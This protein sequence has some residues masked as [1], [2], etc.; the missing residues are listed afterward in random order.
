[1][2]DLRNSRILVVDDTDFNRLVLATIL[3]KDYTITTS[4]DGPGA[5]AHAQNDPPPDLILLDIMMPGMDGFEVCRRL[6][7][8]KTTR[9]IPII[10]I[11]ALKGAEHTSKGFSLGAVDYITKPFD[12]T[13]ILARVKTHLTLRK[14]QESLKQQNTLLQRTIAKQILSISLAKHIMTLVNGTPP[15]Y[16][17]L[18][19]DQA[20][21]IEALTAPCNAEGG[22][23]YF[24][25]ALPPDPAHPEGRTVFSIKDQSGHEVECI[26]RSILT[27]LAHN[28]LLS[29]GNGSLAE[30]VNHLN[31]SICAT[32]FFADDAFCT[33]MTAELDHATR[34]LRFVSAGHPPFLLIRGTT[35]ESLP[36]QNDPGSNLPLIALRDT[37]YLA[38]ETTL[39]PG[40]RLLFYTDGLTEMPLRNRQR[41]L[42]RRDLEKLVGELIAKQP[43][44][45][46]HALVSDLLTT[47][48]DLSD[49]QVHPFVANS[50]ADDV[51]LLGV[52]LQD[53]RQYEERSIQPV[54]I[55]DLDRHTADLYE[56]LAPELLKRGFADPEMRIN[57]TLAE[58]L[59]NAWKHGNKM[60]PN[61]TVTIRWRF[62]NDLVLEVI[63]QGD[64]FD[65]E[66]LP[67]PTNEANI[68]KTA[69]RGIFIIRTLASF[70]S[71][72]HGGR[73]MVV[74]FEKNPGATQKKLPTETSRLID[75]W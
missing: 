5:I 65:P 23:H 36:R 62:G 51:S 3:E 10:F 33:A 24:V 7:E 60:Q 66:A 20:I 28:A 64:G 59:I 54:D 48:A 1:M 14:A 6:K 50:S 63:D 16:I 57:T 53:W 37:R 49:E 15:R 29:K 38:G 9:E 52:E 58:A 25:R 19:D 18:P 44:M 68:T 11:T 32:G 72:R 4:A 43:E 61:K 42:D 31:S 12:D 40:D 17:L 67:D 34:T 2:H 74:A 13:E 27:D 8:N 56:T 26:L 75:L 35:V 69:G 70:L 46:L 21:Q 45:T 71:W 41:V 47:V 30:T 73:Q 55:A 22:D 39:A